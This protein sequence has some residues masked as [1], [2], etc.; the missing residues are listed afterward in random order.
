MYSQPVKNRLDPFVAFWDTTIPNEGEQL[1]N[2]PLALVVDCL[3]GV[4][5]SH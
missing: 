4:T 3:D 2:H 5:A 1:F